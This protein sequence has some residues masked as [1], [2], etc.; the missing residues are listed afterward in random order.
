MNCAILTIGDE[1]LIGQTVN[2][3]AASIA[4]Q[5]TQRAGVSFPVHSTVADDTGVI[6]AE[7]RRLSE[8]ADVIITTGGLGP[9]HD[10]KTVASVAEFADVPLIRDNTWVD[11]LRSMMVALGRELTPRNEHQAMVPATAQVWYDSIGTAPGFVIEVPRSTRTPLTVCVLPGVPSEMQYLTDEHVVPLLQ[12]KMMESGDAVTEFRTVVTSGIP[13]ST[14]ADL[15]GEPEVWARGAA[16]A[17][18]PHAHGVRIRVG[19]TATDARYRTETLGQILAY[20]R[21]QAERYV[22]G[23]DDVTLASAVG[24]I[25]RRHSQT[26]AV[27]ESCTAGMLGSALTDV[28]GSSAWFEGGVISYSNRV[29]QHLLSVTLET[30]NTVGAV[31]SQVAAQMAEGARDAVGATWGV[32]ITGIAGPD[33]GTADKPV[34][35]VWIGIAGPHGTTTTLRRFTGNRSMIRSRATATALTLLYQTL[36]HEP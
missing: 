30:L 10:D 33:G 18:L 4:W 14:L 24:D 32:G 5:C 25:L 26:V 23:T 7:L 36:I 27:A 16:V 9:T 3:N 13:E 1:L 12:N 28:P 2:T 22:V 8:L 31:S 29:K 17:F 6:V 34:G 35:T 21:S 20:I 11:H 19:V 15:L